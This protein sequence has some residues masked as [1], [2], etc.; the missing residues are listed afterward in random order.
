MTSG[1]EALDKSRTIKIFLMA[2]YDIL[3]A[4][5][6]GIKK[7]VM[8]R[9]I[10]PRNILV[11]LFGVPTEALVEP[12][13]TKTILDNSGQ[14]HPPTA[15]LCDLDNSGIFEGETDYRS[16]E[17]LKSPT[18]KGTPMFIARAVEAGRLLGGGH[19]FSPMPELSNKAIAER[20]VGCYQGEAMRTFRD[21][22]GKCHGGRPNE[23]RQREAYFSD[24]TTKALF[25]HQPRHDVESVGWCIIAFCLR[26]QPEDRQGV[27]DSTEELK[28]VWLLLS[29]P[30]RE[31][32]L[33]MTR[34][35][36]E[37]ALHPSL[38]FLSVFLVKLCM[39]MGPEYGLL[40]PPPAEDHLH[41]AFQRLLL[42]QISEMEKDVDLDTMTF[43]EVIPELQRAEHRKMDVP[44]G[45]STG[46]SSDSPSESERRP[47]KRSASIQDEPT[48]S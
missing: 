21:E 39:Q 38:K 29:G 9:D 20:Y 30:E 5:R 4:L 11:N 14:R 17:L 32:V 7:H 27:E 42:N 40:E 34:Q 23:S 31:I 1:G 2:M 24:E 45:P 43:R 33:R 19:L 48:T 16:I 35:D 22:E 25:Y 8:H 26:S 12:T 3:E 18:M 10:S 28:R 15:L 36:W 46:Q 13:F 41:E 6:Y 37:R 47:T 44:F